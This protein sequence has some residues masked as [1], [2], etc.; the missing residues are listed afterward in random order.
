MAS[1]AFSSSELRKK[2][3]G[4]MIGALV[5]DCLG[6]P[7]EIEGYVLQSKQKFINLLNDVMSGGL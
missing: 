3:R 6:A 5:G 1:S 2:F 4:C 7:F